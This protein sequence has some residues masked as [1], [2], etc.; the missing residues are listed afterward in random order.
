LLT[1]DLANVGAI[2]SASASIFF[3]NLVLIMHF[4]NTYTNPGGSPFGEM[5]KSLIKSDDAITI[6]G[7]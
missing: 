1:I 6:N 7:D 4:A 2:R 5:S 3:H